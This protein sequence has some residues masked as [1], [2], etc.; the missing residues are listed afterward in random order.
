MPVEALV[1]TYPQYPFELVRGEG[2]FVFDR[3][4]KRYLDLYGGHAV[5]LIGHSPGELHE[6]LS[7]QAQTLH[8]YSNLTPLEI[9]SRAAEGLLQFADSKLASVFFCNS[10]AEANENALRIALMLTG[11]KRLVSLKGGFHGRT[12]ICANV[13][14]NPKW[15]ESMKGWTGDVLRLPPNEKEALQQI[16][17]SCAALILE[18]IQS[19]GGVNVIEAEYLKAVRERCDQTGTLLIFDEIQTGMGRTGVPFVNG[20]C[21]V[22]ADMSTSAKGLGGGFPVGA[23]LMTEEIA[24]EISVGDLGSTFGGGPL[25]AASVAAT[26][27]SIEHRSLL[28]NARELGEKARSLLL[29]EGVEQVLGRGLLLGLRLKSRPAREVT[30]E[31]QK[32]GVL[33]GTSGVPEVMRL[34]PPLTVAEE[35]LHELR[36]KLSLILGAEQ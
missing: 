11:R 26:L 15:H 27:R 13:T 17:D 3:D 12:T 35:H 21:G 25:A 33:T 1:E 22:Q 24:Q 20:H 32:R 7:S 2:N 4:G 30:A 23:V 31:L 28:E 14:D 9:R 6:A 18:P 29:I 34:L 36:D 19:I 10:G 16:D 5:C 8:F